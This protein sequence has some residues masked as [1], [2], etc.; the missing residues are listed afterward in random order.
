MSDL[1]RRA[2]L[3][4][5]LG[6]SGALTAWGLLRYLTFPS[7]TARPATFVL[8]APAAYAL[9]TITAVPEARA[10]I[11]RD[12]RGLYALSAV[13][14]H[15]G[16]TLQARDRRYECACH[17]SRFDDRGA[18]LNGPAQRPLDRFSLALSAEG[19]VVLDVTQTVSPDFR[20]GV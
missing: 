10:F 15:L 8:Q 18:V 5:T 14:T 7:P 17:G 11:G 6:L 12:A 20:L 2:A 9:D 13:C 16:C 4:I 19:R 3:K 1:S